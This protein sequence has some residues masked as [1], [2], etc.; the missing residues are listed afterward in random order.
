MTA[1]SL[2]AS[3]TAIAAPATKKTGAA[4]GSTGAATGSTGGATTSATPV[5]A[6]PTAEPDPNSPDALSDEAIARF[7]A[8]DYDGA[9]DHFERA[10]AIDPK[11]N[12]L[13][14]I[15]RVYEEAGRLPE[16]VKY[17]ERFLR[18][19]GVDLES[20]E[21]ALQRLRVLRAIIAETTPKET[22]PEPEPEPEPPRIVT[23]EPEPEP[24]PM[25]RSKKLRIAGY[26]LLGVGGA[27]IVLGAA[28]GGIASKQAKD[29]ETTDGYNDRQELI[30]VGQTNAKI[31]DVAFLTGGVVALTG[32]VLV[33]TTL[34]KKSRPSAEARVLSPLVGRGQVGL[35]VGGRF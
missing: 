20:R 3:S 19:P 16:A 12:F 27:G 4:A 28:F 8:K 34:G 33:L 17:Y 5:E 7:K 2:L 11:P 18:E 31:A 6:P 23:P 15:G 22:V 29:L 30:R 25:P 26:T 10:Y 21:I 1:V 14:N 13:F 9:V 32:L 35:A 24:E